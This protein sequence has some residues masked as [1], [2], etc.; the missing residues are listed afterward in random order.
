MNIML[1]INN[2]KY[3]FFDIYGTIAGFYPEREKIQQK[4]LSQNN[5]FLTEAQISF[6]Y[7]SAD[8]YMANQKKIKPLRDFTQD[9]KKIF[10]SNYQNKILESNGILIDQKKLWRIWE[11][12]SN[13]SK[14][15]LDTFLAPLIISSLFN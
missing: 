13:A 2:I 12:I 10:F 4:I 3:I 6:G 5:I 15:S 9:E 7:K 1:P 11:E 14:R 8:E